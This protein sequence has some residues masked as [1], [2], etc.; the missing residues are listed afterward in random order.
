MLSG[1]IH[2][3]GVRLD[4]PITALIGRNGS[5]KASTLA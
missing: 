1:E 4:T 5:G 3:I 2:P